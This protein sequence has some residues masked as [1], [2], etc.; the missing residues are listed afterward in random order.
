[1]KKIYIAALAALFCVPAVAQEGPQAEMPQPPAF[2][3]G[4][5]PDMQA[6]REAHEAHHAQMKATQ[7]KMENLVKAYNKLKNGKKK[8]AKLAEI[9]AEVAAIHEKQLDFKRD[10]LNKFE[11]RLEK[12]RDEFN[13]QNATDVKQAWVE[14]HTEKLIAGNGNIEVL[15]KPEFA[16]KKGDMR[17]M[18]PPFKG[19]KGHGPK[20]GFGPKDGRGP[21]AELPVE[22]P[23]EK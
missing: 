14:Q 9:Q 21:V 13:R 11:R 23:V 18:K 4:Q 22:R 10:Q 6:F 17:G 12:M 16:G 20:K 8:E 2:E 15:F 3:Q 1:M 19:P 7:E 5:G